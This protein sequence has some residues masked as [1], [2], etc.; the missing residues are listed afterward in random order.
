MPAAAALGLLFAVG[1]MAAAVGQV[2]SL[3]T[4]L[5]GVTTGASNDW[6]SLLLPLF[7]F[8]GIIVLIGFLVAMVR[9]FF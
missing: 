1:L 3:R 5:L 2:D 4:A 9:L 8:V 7:V 6:A